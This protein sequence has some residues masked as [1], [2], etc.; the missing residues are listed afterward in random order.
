MTHTEQIATIPANAAREAT[1][2]VLLALRVQQL[3]DSLKA[4]RDALRERIQATDQWNEADGLRRELKKSTKEQRDEIAEQLH[5]ARLAV[6]A[7]DEA[8]FVDRIKDDLK[9]AK[10][11]LASALIDNR[12]MLL[13][14]ARECGVE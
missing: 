9:H 5:A 13:P 12:Q 14:F 4:G 6:A 1:R 3:Q 2:T 8:Q 11:A 10:S 7:T